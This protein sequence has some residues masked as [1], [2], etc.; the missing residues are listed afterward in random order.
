MCVWKAVVLCMLCV[1]IS[2]SYL[3][4]VAACAIDSSWLIEFFSVNI[5]F[6][7]FSS[8][9]SL[10]IRLSSLVCCFVSVFCVSVCDSEKEWKYES[11]SEH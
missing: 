4:D 5:L 9:L 8:L 1:E 2:K 11:N 7:S 10:L 3:C 6:F